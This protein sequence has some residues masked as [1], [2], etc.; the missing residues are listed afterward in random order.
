MS[1]NKKEEV[2]ER[3]GPVFNPPVYI[4]R[5]TTVRDILFKLPGVVKVVDFGCAEGNF[6]KYLKK[7]PFATE[8]SCIDLHEP[9]LEK[10][11][12]VSRPNAW[13]FVFKR[14][15]PLKIKIFKGSALENDFRLQGYDAVTCIELCNGVL[16]R[17]P[18]Y[19]VKI[20]G[21]GD[22][23]PESSHLGSLSQLAV[24]MLKASST[25]HPY[26]INSNAPAETYVLIDEHIYP[27]RS[28]AD[29]EQVT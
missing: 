8:I 16:D 29:S 24:F 22:P 25:R 27:G 23:P 12:H 21:V 13:D 10:A 11:V 3:S 7:L 18:D 5:Y 9:S 2:L 15:Q 14:H 4:Q 17:F 19:T 28:Q 1:E 6:I 26:T 20:Q